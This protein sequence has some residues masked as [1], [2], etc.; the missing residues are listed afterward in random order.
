MGGDAEVSGFTWLEGQSLRL[1]AEAIAAN[2]L[3][4]RHNSAFS[5]LD[6]EAS[7]LF[8]VLRDFDAA[9][10]DNAPPT[11]SSL[12]VV[13]G[14]D[15][16][17]WLLKCLV[18]AVQS[19]GLANLSLRQ[20]DRCVAILFGEEEWPAQW[21]LSLFPHRAA[22]YS[23]NGIAFMTLI[24][25]DDMIWGLSANVAGIPLLLS[26]GIGHS[27][28]LTFHPAGIVF[29]HSDRAGEKVLGFAW[30]GD[31]ASGFLAFTRSEPYDGEPFTPF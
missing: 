10:G 15:I 28:R 9:L 1:P 14:P 4:Q 11:S 18:G 20:P 19:G 17:K 25:P 31:P 22:E 3:C 7:R 29:S 16:E 6:Q 8:E 13:N 2:I 26:V 24:G 12:A 23:Y 30:P 27:E 21:G 5:P